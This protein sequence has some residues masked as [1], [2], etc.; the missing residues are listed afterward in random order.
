MLIKQD[1]EVNLTLIHHTEFMHHCMELI[2]QSD[3]REQAAQAM[4]SY[5]WRAWNEGMAA[6][7]YQKYFTKWGLKFPFVFLVAC[8][9][10][11][12]AR[13]CS[14]TGIGG[15]QYNIGQFLALIGAVSKVGSAARSICVN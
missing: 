7:W 4:Y 15:I 11:L 13:L 6:C 14:E 9:Y 2:R 3:R 8:I 12:G 5:L 1:E 10:A